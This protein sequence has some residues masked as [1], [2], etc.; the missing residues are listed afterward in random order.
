MWAG[1]SF[2]RVFDIILIFLG[3]KKESHFVKYL[4]RYLFRLQTVNHS[5]TFWRKSCH[6]VRG[7]NDD[8][9]NYNGNILKKKEHQNKVPLR[10]STDQIILRKKK[11][12]SLKFKTSKMCRRYK[13]KDETWSMETIEEW[14]QSKQYS[15]KSEQTR[16]SVDKLHGSL[17]AEGNDVYWQTVAV[18]YLVPQENKDAESLMRNSTV[19]ETAGACFRRFIYL[20]SP[21]LVFTP[22]SG[23][24]LEQIRVE[25]WLN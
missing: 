24:K 2:R 6:S 15:G 11:K 23:L 20:F 10:C 14:K 1:E 22:Q 21:A 5:R 19:T 4:H 25:R 12:N 3:G 9:C 18:S 8:I 17:M 7:V 16:H 13:E